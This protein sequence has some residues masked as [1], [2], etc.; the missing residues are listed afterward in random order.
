MTQ[1]PDKLPLLLMGN[2]EA[3]V[4]HAS[5]IVDKDHYQ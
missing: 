2:T 4:V 3:A 5:R 1:G